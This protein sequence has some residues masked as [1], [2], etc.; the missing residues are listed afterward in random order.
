MLLADIVIASVAIVC[1]IVLLHPRLARARLWRATITPLASIIGSGFL[2]AG[3]ILADATG[4]Q[5]WLAM[6]SLCGVA[7]LFGAAIRYNIRHVEPVLRETAD[8]PTRTIER[9]SEAVLAVAYFISVAYYLSLFASFGL[10]LVNITDPTLSRW[11]ATAVIATLGA[12]GGIGG[13][14]EL[15]R[16]AAYTVGLKLGLIFAVI[17]ALVGSS[18]FAMAAGTFAWPALE[19]PRGLNEL[20]IVLGL[21]ILV[22]GFETSRYLG[23]EYDAET[24]IRTMR[25]AQWLSTA[26]YASFIL[27]ATRFFQNQLPAEGGETAIIDILA[28]LGG[29]IAPMIILTALASQSSAAIADTNGA[30]G[31]LSEATGKRVSV[32]VGNILTAAA[33][34]AIIW[35]ADIYEIIVYASKAFV[36]YYALQCIQAT[37]M[38]ARKRHSIDASI[39]AVGVIIAFIVLILAVPAS[40]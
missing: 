21:V 4:Q 36:G 15:E 32:K 11:V 13:L 14:R 29:I 25:W 35:I 16:L 2:I 3:P 18:I 17:F 31:L 30:G 10:R 39:Y 33:A 22:Q 6:L 7:Y 5:A 9:L 12:V 28:P 34:I 23:E 38:A 24:R 37:V 40:A 1:C 20:Q 27:L 26:I 8:I 19:H